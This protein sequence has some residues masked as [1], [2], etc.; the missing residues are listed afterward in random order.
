MIKSLRSD[1]ETIHLQ[2]HPMVLQMCMGFMKGDRDQAHDLAQEVFINAWTALEGY[3]GDS[4]VKTWIYR[5]TVNTCLM[6]LRKEKTR[7]RLP[8]D[9]AHEGVADESASSHE[10]TNELYA[11]IGRLDHVDRLIIM[12]VLDELEYEEIARIVGITENNLRVKIHR[13]KHKLKTLIQHG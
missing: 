11:A 4:S 3:R 6:H 7:A 1:F 9:N 10:Q 13:I 5:I 12:M 2:Y 8:L